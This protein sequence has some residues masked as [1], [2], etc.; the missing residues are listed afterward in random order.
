MGAREEVLK[1]GPGGGELI[2]LAVQLVVGRTQLLV[3]R[4]QLLVCRS[5]FFVGGVE[6]FHHNLKVRARVEKLVLQAADAGGVGA[7]GAGGCPGGG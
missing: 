3:G 1:V 2:D 5:E 6:L 4:G 7:L